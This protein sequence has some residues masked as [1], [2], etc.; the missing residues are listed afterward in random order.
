MNKCPQDLVFMRFCGINVCCKH[1]L[2]KAGIVACCGICSVGCWCRIE[3]GEV[4]A[5]PTLRECSCVA[6]S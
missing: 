3:R 1:G 4:K 6:T 5:T 2:A